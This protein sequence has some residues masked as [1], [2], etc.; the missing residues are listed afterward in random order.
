MAKT[1]IILSVSSYCAQQKY[2]IWKLVLSQTGTNTVMS[3]LS[4]STACSWFEIQGIFRC[5]ES[6]DTPSECI[7]CLLS[8]WMKSFKCGGTSQ[9]IVKLV[10]RVGKQH[11]FRNQ[12]LQDFSNQKD[13]SWTEKAKAFF[14]GEREVLF[15]YMYSY[16]DTCPSSTAA[17]PIPLL[18][19]VVILARYCESY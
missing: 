2:V 17:F 6:F 10:T 14:Y 9:I 5:Q 15:I 3:E 4:G 8:K 11:L 12:S 1:I 16:S 13:M 19:N 18:P 7:N